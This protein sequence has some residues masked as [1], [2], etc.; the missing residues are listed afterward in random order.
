MYNMRAIQ[1]VGAVKKLHAPSMP[2]YLIT[3]PDDYGMLM[4]TLIVSRPRV[5]DQSIV[6]CEPKMGLICRHFRM[7]REATL[8]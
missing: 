4:I 2:I 6:I 3:M 8:A 1:Y 5:R 7:D